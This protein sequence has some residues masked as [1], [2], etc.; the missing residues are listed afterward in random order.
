M[1]QEQFQ[2]NRTELLSRIREA[3]TPPT[4][5][6]TPEWNAAAAEA[7]TLSMVAVLFAARRRPLVPADVANV[8]FVILQVAREWVDDV[9]LP[10]GD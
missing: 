4:Q 8:A 9:A 7:L 6:A 1:D 2:A 10:A 5:P 3:L